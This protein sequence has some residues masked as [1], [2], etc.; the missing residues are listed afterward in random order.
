VTAAHKGGRF[1]GYG[2]GIC[3]CAPACFLSSVGNRDALGKAIGLDTTG[4][5]RS[6][7]DRGAIAAIPPDADRNPAVSCDFANVVG[8]TS[9]KPSLQSQPIRIAKGQDRS[10]LAATRN[11]RSHHG[12]EM[13]VNRP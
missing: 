12:A 3:F 7:D 8:A 9:S 11:S 6:R 2:A 13:S 4:S 1:H 5:A 10:D